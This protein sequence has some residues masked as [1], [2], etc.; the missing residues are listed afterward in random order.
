MWRT[1]AAADDVRVSGF[2]GEIDNLDGFTRYESLQGRHAAHHDS[3]TAS[4]ESIQSALG[5][6]MNNVS[7]D[8]VPGHVDQHTGLE[9]ILWRDRRLALNGGRAAIGPYISSEVFGVYG[10]GSDETAAVQ[11][12]VTEATKYGAVIVWPGRVYGTGSSRVVRIS[13]TVNVPNRCR[14]IGGNFQPLADDAFRDRGDG[15]PKVMFTWPDRGLN[16]GWWEHGTVSGP[17]SGPPNYGIGLHLSWQQP[18]SIRHMIF[19]NLVAGMHVNG[20]VGRLDTIQFDG[21]DVGLLCTGQTLSMHCTSLSF[22]VGGNRVGVMYD[23]EGTYVD[24]AGIDTLAMGSVSFRGSH[25]EVSGNDN[26]TCFDIGSADM[27]TIYDTLVSNIDSPTTTFYWMR[28]RST[29]GKYKSNYEI[30]RVRIYRTGGHFTTVQDDYRNETVTTS[31]WGDR[32]MYPPHI[33]QE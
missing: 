9:S 3:L 31:T 12:C 28:D 18:S 4:V 11:E 27:L 7:P 29:Y 14:M 32:L 6:N 15:K 10:D 24:D 19:A 13:D 25:F 21:N 33:R 17:A 26:A 1:V 30:G 23:T 8:T 5:R 16:T 2:P 22:I 20:Q